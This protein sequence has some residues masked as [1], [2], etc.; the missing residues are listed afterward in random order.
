MTLE[1]ELNLSARTATATFH[2]RGQAGYREA[3]QLRQE[4]FAAIDAAGDKNLVVE[5][6]EVS[7]IDTAAMAVLVEGL[8]ATHDRGP[9]MFLVCPNES[10][11]RVFELAGLEE[12]LLRCYSCWGDFEQAM[13]A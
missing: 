5:L 6:D 3:A 12:A 10:V 13:T 1:T 9:T 8:V 2:L 7:R 11:R 4:L